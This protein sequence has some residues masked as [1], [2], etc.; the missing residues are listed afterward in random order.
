LAVAVFGR[1]GN[2]FTADVSERDRDG[3]RRIDGD[4]REPQ[5]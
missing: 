4:A 1:G 5:G 3:G 2:Q